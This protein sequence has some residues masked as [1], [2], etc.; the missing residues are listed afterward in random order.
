MDGSDHVHVRTLDEGTVPVD[1]Q[2]LN[3]RLQ[4]DVGLP[5]TDAYAESVR[6]WNGTITKRPALVARARGTADV[7]ETVRFAR[8]HGLHLSVRGGGHNIAGLALTDGGLTL[9]LSQMR[10]VL[11][12]PG[13]RVARVQAGCLLHDVDRE[14]QVHG[15]ATPLGFVSETGVAGLT[16]GGGF[17]YLTRKHGWTVD[18][19]LEAEVVTA[20]GDVLRASREEHPDLFWALRGG[21]GNFGV[22]TELA[23]QLHE[24]GP[25]VTGGLAAWPAETPEETRAAQDA[26]R[27]FTATAPRDLTVFQILRKAPPAPWIPEAWHGRRVAVFVICHVGTKEEADA[28]LAGLHEALGEPVASIVKRRPYAELQSLTDQTQPTGEHYYWK[29]EW[30]SE[31]TG[32]LLRTVR[33]TARNIPFPAGQITLAH[34]GGALNEHPEDD[35]AVG[36]R[37]ARFVVAAQGMWAPDD[38]QGERNRAWVR[39]AWKALRPH[40]TGGNYVNFQTADEDAKRVQ[41]TYRKN[42]TRLQRVKARYDPGN[43]FRV[44]R[45]I[46]PAPLEDAS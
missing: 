27:D 42:L 43:L 39:D 29:S 28:D 25:E 2:V 5:G 34:V 20:S 22:V 46:E 45:N 14:T 38:P 16:L 33:E 7:V 9:D 10:G 23:F 35:G 36:N 37:D 24:V 3:D 8:E 1:P 17:G 40:G 31:L 21:G 6:I 15:L 11:V 19:L 4:G 41:A 13:A 18:N 12:D 32:D 30:A 26:Y 44:N